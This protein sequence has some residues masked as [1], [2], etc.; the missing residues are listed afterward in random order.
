MT[1]SAVWIKY[2]MVPVLA[3]STG[4]SE[5]H[6]E[7]RLVSAKTARVYRSVFLAT[8]ENCDV[9]RE[10]ESNGSGAVKK[11]EAHGHKTVVC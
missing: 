11:R 3:F 5:F 8:S 9:T 7:S 2:E 1:L 4:E 6:Q 10:T